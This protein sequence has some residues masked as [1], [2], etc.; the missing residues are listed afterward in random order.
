[1]HRVALAFFDAVIDHAE[2]CML[3]EPQRVTRND[4]RYAEVVDETHPEVHDALGVQGID[5]GSRLVS[6]EHARL[7]R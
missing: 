2:P 7:V 4:E 6:D 5:G 1:V 3:H